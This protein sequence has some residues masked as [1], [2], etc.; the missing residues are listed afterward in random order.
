MKVS[1]Y[2]R[3]GKHLGWMRISRQ[4]ER[5][6]SSIVTNDSREASDYTQEE[7]KQFQHMT[8]H[9]FKGE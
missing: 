4:E 2:T 8:S 7:L 6:N 5:V 3:E 1:V 9:I